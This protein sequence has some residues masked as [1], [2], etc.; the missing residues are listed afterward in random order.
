MKPRAHS[1]GTRF[2]LVCTAL[3]VLSGTALAADASTP[4][5]CG[6]NGC[7]RLRTSTLQ[8]LLTLP[9]ALQ[10]AAPP[11][12]RPFVLFR[13]VDLD[14]AAHEVVYVRR[15]GE[16]LLGF[17]G[18]QGWRLVPADDAKLLA[19]AAAERAPYPAPEAGTPLARLFAADE[20][21]GWSAAWLAGA[22]LIVS[23]VAAVAVYASVA[24]GSRR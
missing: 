7:T 21:D 13:V 3:A 22:A 20:P 18:G 10:P 23:G 14:G 5:A 11:R 6:S 1:T 24:V 16:A 8:G 4:V 15:D 9:A 12:A 17:A 19:D 2:A